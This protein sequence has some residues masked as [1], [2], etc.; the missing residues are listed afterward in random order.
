M[1]DRN[2]ISSNR[3]RFGEGICLNRT[4]YVDELLPLVHGVAE[5]FTRPVDSEKL[6]DLTGRLVTNNV[7]DTCDQTRSR[8]HGQVFCHV[9]GNTAKGKCFNDAF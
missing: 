6:T 9:F 5:R 7:P 3:S 1:F 2:F 8:R 4:A